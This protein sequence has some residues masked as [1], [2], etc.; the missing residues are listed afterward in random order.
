M[1]IWVPILGAVLLHAL[2]FLVPLSERA[3]SKQARKN[4]D[5]NIVVERWEDQEPKQSVQTSRAEEQDEG[6]KARFGG[7]FRNRVKK[8]TRSPVVGQFREGPQPGNSLPDDKGNGLT[9][10]DLL[11]YGSQSDVLPDDVEIGGQTLLNTDPFIYSSFMNRVHDEVHGPWSRRVQ[12]VARTME[13]RLREKTYITKLL[14]SVD[15]DGHVL[16]I[17]TMQSCGIPEIDNAAREAIWESEPFPD[18]P[19]N[20]KEFTEPLSLPYEFHVSVTNAS[21]LMMP[22]RL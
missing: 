4:P 18:P 19:K 6:G 10:S 21:F 20:Y 13:D 8:E 9:L 22:W 11:P 14:V 12:G 17:R 16:S 2:L 15:E 5:D 7:E 3:S 1:Q